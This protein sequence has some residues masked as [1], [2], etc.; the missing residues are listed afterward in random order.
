MLWLKELG[1]KEKYDTQKT[2]Q[3]TKDL[4]TRTPQKKMW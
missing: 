2:T 3:K 4:S 1:H